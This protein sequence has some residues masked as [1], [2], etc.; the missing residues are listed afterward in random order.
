MVQLTFTRN[1][2]KKNS[3]PLQKSAYLL[4]S[5]SLIAVFK[6]LHAFANGYKRL[7]TYNFRLCSPFRLIFALSI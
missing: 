1:K 3:Q 4:H 7:Q 5:Q 2:N 6:R